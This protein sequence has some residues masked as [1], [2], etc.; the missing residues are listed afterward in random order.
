MYPKLLHGYFSVLST[1][2]SIKSRKK[3]LYVEMYLANKDDSD[4]EFSG[5]ICEAIC[6]IACK[7]GHEQI[8]LIFYPCCEDGVNSLQNVLYFRTVCF[9]IIVHKPVERQTFLTVGCN[10]L[11]IQ[12]MSVTRYLYKKASL[13]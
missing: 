12:Q 6:D 8:H 7:K 2:R 1:V 3:S 9:K 4:S 5:R 10:A 13:R 11:C